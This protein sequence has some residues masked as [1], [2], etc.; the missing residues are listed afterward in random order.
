[1]PRRLLLPCDELCAS[2][3]A[4]Q[5]TLVL[6]RRYTCSPTTI[7]SHLRRCGVELRRARFAAIAI[8]AATLRRM[9]LDERWPV[10][11]IAAHF[12]VSASTVGNKRRRYGIAPR[13]RRAEKV[14][15]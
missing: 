1:M 12:G 15:G 13:P 5:T 8:D 6:A 14:R 2:Y 7:A 3:L 4:G 11:A 10:S 9:Y